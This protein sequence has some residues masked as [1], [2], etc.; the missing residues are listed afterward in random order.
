VLV[1]EE[2]EKNLN[3]FGAIERWNWVAEDQELP[4]APVDWRER[5]VE[6]L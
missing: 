4:E 6:K 5:H 2:P 1:R 3:I